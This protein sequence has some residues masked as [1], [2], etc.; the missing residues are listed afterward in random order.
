MSRCRSKT[1]LGWFVLGCKGLLVT[2]V[3]LGPWL[4]G[5]FWLVDWLGHVWAAHFGK[6]TVLWPPAAILGCYIMFVVW[7]FFRPEDPDGAVL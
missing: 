4:V 7:S 2:T 1:R 6:D 3:L 5:F